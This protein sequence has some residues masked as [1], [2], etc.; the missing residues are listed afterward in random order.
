VDLDTVADE[1]YGLPPS[2]FVG[3]RNDRVKQARA[4][5]DRALATAI[6][7]LR[8]PSIGAWTVN[9][10]VRDRAE[11]VDQLF[12]LAD[13]LRSAQETL[14]G[15]ELRTLSAQRHRV[16]AS[17]VT[18]ARKL[19]AARGTKLSDATEREL[20]AT[21]DAALA[22]PDAAAAVRSGRLE[23]GLTYSGLG[24]A[25]SAEPT[26]ARP[27]TARPKAAP[28]EKEARAKAAREAAREALREAETDAGHARD[29][30]ATARAAADRAASRRDEAHRRVNELTGQLEAAQ[31][32][33]TDA[34]TA[35]REQ[36][37]LV[38]RAERRAQDAQRQLDRARAAAEKA[39]A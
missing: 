33:V 10:L 31:S 9:L 39:G 21:L 2:E 14:S 34:L 20:E 16:V 15:P 13:A 22:D 4:D 27:T 5:G 26:T 8:R 38:S 24:L 30:A 37:R 25:P 19:A 12:E 3:V 28:P 32:E 29:D 11:L 36:Q 18:E 17:V 1:L 7:A 23:S 6:G 35:A